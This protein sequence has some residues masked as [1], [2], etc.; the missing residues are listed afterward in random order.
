[1][2]KKPNNKKYYAKKP[3]IKKF[4]RISGYTKKHSIYALFIA[5]MILFTCVSATIHKTEL[6]VEP[7]EDIEWYGILTVSESMGYT[8]SILFGESVNAS[9]GFDWFDLPKIIVNP[10]PYI[11]AYFTTDFPWPYHKLIR[12]IKHYPDTHKMWN[13]SIF[14]TE[15]NTTLTINWNSTLLLESEYE[16]MYLFNQ[17]YT[18][19]ADMYETSYYQFNYTQATIYSFHIVCGPANQAPLAFDDFYETDENICLVVD[20]PG[21]LENDYDPDMG[22]KPLSAVLISSVSNGNLTFHSNGSF[23]YTPHLYWHGVDM[24]SYV[25]FDG[26][27]YSNIANVTITVHAVNNDPEALDDYVTVLKNSVDNQVDVLANDYDVDGDE[28]EIINVSMPNFGNVSFDSN[29][30][31]Y[32]PAFDY[33]GEDMFNYTIT[34]NNGSE[35]VTAWVF[36]TVIENIAP[37]KPARPTGPTRGSAGQYYTYS[38]WT[39]D[40]NDDDI[41]YLFDWGDGTTTGWIGPYASGEVVEASHSWEHHDMYIIMVKAKDIFDQESPWSDPLAVSMPKNGFFFN[42]FLMRLLERIRQV[43]PLFDWLVPFC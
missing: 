36:V 1:M 21:V 16:T 3:F 7:P 20:A 30:V 33:V 39:V 6:L 13:F 23:Q 14:W 28:L 26:M 38:S 37:N 18:V 24:F 27:D 22:P 43:F 31:Y 8:D 41:Y 9:D 40:E 19:L 42:S 11:D 35:G 34:D 12:E 25:A 4:L 5:V 29:Y 32:T 15:T 2:Q 10:P 17:Q